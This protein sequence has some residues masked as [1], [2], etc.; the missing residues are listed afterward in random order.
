MKRKSGDEETCILVSY[1]NLPTIM[2]VI[3]PKNPRTGD[4]TRELSSGCPGTPR[5]GDGNN[6]A[7]RF[8]SV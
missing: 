3:K 1:S 2:K 5:K 6:L 8:F 7:P 4:N